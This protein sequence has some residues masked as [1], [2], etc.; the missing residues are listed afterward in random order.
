M[1]A[2]SHEPYYFSTRRNTN[3][4]NIL[5]LQ[6]R[7]F[8]IPLFRYSNCERSELGSISEVRQLSKKLIAIVANIL[9]YVYIVP[10]IM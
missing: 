9:V 3:L 1:A 10:I 7:I 6:R 4:P 5:S 8:D 2:K